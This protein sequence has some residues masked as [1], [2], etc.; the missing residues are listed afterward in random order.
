MALSAAFLAA[1]L[2]ARIPAGAASDELVPDLLQLDETAGQD[3]SG[4]KPPEASDRR[5]Q[6]A[7]LLAEK[8]WP[9]SAFVQL[10]AIADDG[11]QAAGQV[12]ALEQL[13]WLARKGLYDREMM[14]SLALRIRF[15]A[16]NVATESFLAFHAASALLRQQADS[17][18]RTWASE[19][20]QKISES[21]VWAMHWSYHQAL[22]QYREKNQPREAILAL[23]LLLERK[24][25]PSQLRQRIE[26]AIARLFFESGDY[27]KADEIYARLQLGVRDWGRVTLE[28]AWALY[29]LKNYSKALGLLQSL[30]APFFNSS[31]EPERASLE[32]MVLGQVCHASSIVAVVSDAKRVHSRFTE[33]LKRRSNL[34]DDIGLLNQAL[35][36]G[37]LRSRTTSVEML[38]RELPAI[39]KS[40]LKGLEPLVRRIQL[41]ERELR[42]EIR[43]LAQPILTALANESLKFLEQIE[44]LDYQARLAM[45]RQRLSSQPQRRP[46]AVD[47]NRVVWPQRYNEFW[48]DE[49]PLYQ[50]QLENRC[51]I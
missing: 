27:A 50:I 47:L 30:R 34:A 40:G 20:A 51:G 2:F 48:R 23:R 10:V 21:T 49:F 12:E 46:A 18:Q 25:L 42:S 8:G 7:L 24:N 28:R 19:E 31:L 6:A 15:K 9:A 26:L 13:E 36:E 29:H 16:P 17:R 39:Q 32:L 22:R 38:V 35:M 44:F 14:E 45:S 33:R 5:V 4:E 3:Q 41:R 43:V 1:V 11:S 37:P